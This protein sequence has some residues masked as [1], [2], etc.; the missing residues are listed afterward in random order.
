MMNDTKYWKQIQYTPDFVQGVQCDC[1]SP[2]FCDECYKT[3]KVARI[4]QIVVLKDTIPL[5]SAWT[6]RT[7]SNAQSTGTVMKGKEPIIFGAEG[8]VWL[9][10]QDQ[11]Y[12]CD[13]CDHNILWYWTFDAVW[14]ENF[15]RSFL[16]EVLDKAMQEASHISSLMKLSWFGPRTK[17][18]SY[19]KCLKGCITKLK[20][21]RE[22]LQH[23][24]DYHPFFILTLLYLSLYSCLSLSLSSPCIC[25]CLWI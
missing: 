8:Q 2:Q 18:V 4:S 22:K 3:M 19:L 17:W 14:T 7:C 12:I 21:L 6:K 15:L 9:A 16:M 23:L 1:G 5:P 11:L 25:H 20:G 10:I 13:Q 24:N